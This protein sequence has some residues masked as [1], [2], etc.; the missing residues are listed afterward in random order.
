MS[1]YLNKVLKASGRYGDPE[2]I[3]DDSKKEAPEGY[4][5]MPD[6]ELM[7][8]SAHEAA[9]LEKESDDP[10]WKG[11]VQLGTK[12]G[13]DGKEVP[14]CVPIDQSADGITAAA[15]EKESDDP[16]WKGYVQV[17]MKD[18]KGKKVPNCVPSSASITE[19]VYSINSEFGASRAVSLESA[20]AVARK[21]CTKYSYLGDNDALRSAILWE[22]FT[23]AEYATSG[24]SEDLDD[25]SDYS[26]LLPEGHPGVEA[27]IYASALWIS[28]APE[29]DDS[30][31]FAIT[32]TYSNSADDVSVLHSAVR[33]K[34]LIAS[35]SLGETTLLQLGRL[36]S[37]PRKES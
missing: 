16:C 20:Y 29:L 12:K 31:R 27:P 26:D 7:K 2:E 36:A 34:V 17:G 8:D 32:Q 15:L 10:C 21:A 4:H 37:M 13:K 6:G 24:E 33:I 9:S 5:Y 14:N 19:V 11:Y 35:G 22:V 30:Q 1:E 3:I 23:F 28:G 25:L 18:K